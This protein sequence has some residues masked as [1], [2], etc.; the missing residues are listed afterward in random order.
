MIVKKIT[1]KMVQ[2]DAPAKINLF[3]Q[4]LS[5][6][7]DG[8]H[9]IN[10][11]FQAVSLHD[12]LE[13]ESVD[14]R[15]VSIRMLNDIDLP[16]G[17]DNLI[18]RAFNLVRERFDL[19]TGLA[20]ALDK[21]IPIAAGLGGGSADAAATIL[22]C[23]KLFNL[24]LSRTAMAQLGSE[25]GSDLPFFFSRG[26]ALVSGR[27][28]IVEEI[29]LPMDYQLVMIT[30]NRGVSTAA[31]YS[32]LKMD[33]TSAG[34]SHKMRRCETAKELAGALTLCGNDFER[35]QAEFFADLKRIKEGL[36]EQ[37][38]M[39]VRM[40][41][42]GPTVFGMFDESCDL[43]IDILSKQG[44]WQINRAKPIALSVPVE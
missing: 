9:N 29:T 41:G 37:G 19:K 32:A 42:S 11:L 22:A 3:L 18:T 23:N 31:A 7:E 12:H 28:E 21:R 4:V 26:Q 39:L 13:F 44:D 16:C 1:N 15:G 34:V 5:K 27:G 10:S 25:I 20:V 17:N 38:A 33:L 24:N 14:S 43:N 8:F 2:I 35:L 30:P 36:A 40:S 6:R